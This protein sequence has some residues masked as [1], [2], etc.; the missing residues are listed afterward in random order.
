LV[1]KEL[2]FRKKK[3]HQVY[4]HYFMVRILNGGNKSDQCTYQ[5]FR[6]YPRTPDQ[7]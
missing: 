1:G 3:A 4:L 2:L 7:A 5:I 6:T